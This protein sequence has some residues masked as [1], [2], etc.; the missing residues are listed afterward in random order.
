MLLFKQSFE[1]IEKTNIDRIEVSTLGKRNAAEHGQTGP[2][3]ETQ[4]PLSKRIKV[5]ESTC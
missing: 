3:T 2:E 5:S 4:Q 1:I